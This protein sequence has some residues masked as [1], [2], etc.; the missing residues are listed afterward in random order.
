PY[1]DM[2][3]LLRIKALNGLLSEAPVPR[4]LLGDPRCTVQT[5]GQTGFH[6]FHPARPMEVRRLHRGELSKPGELMAPALPAVLGSLDTEVV[7]PKKRRSALA[8][9]LTSP[10]NPLTA[11]VLVNR[12]WGWHFGQGIVRTPNDFGAQGEPPTHPELLDLL[13]RDLVDHGW[14]LK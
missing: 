10:D 4:K 3:R 5:E 14:G 12:V 7:A 1:P 6:L 11:R 13:A 8:K 9:W 2:V